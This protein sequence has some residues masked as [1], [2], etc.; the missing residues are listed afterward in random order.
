MAISENGVFSILPERFFSPLSGP[1][2]KHYA[3]L[4]LRFYR[5]FKENTR[6]ALREQVIGDFVE[7]VRAAGSIDQTEGDDNDEPDDTGELGTDERGTAAA[8]LRRLVDAGWLS[9]E[10]LSDYSR[11]VNITP[12]SRPFLE[13]LDK[14]EQGRTAEYE[15]HVVAV[16]SNLTGDAINDAGHLAVLSANRETQDLI[17]S[18][19]AL[20]QSIKDYYERLSDEESAKEVKDILHLQ[21]D[22][23]TID[24]LDA[25]YKRLKTSDNLSRYR[26]KIFAKI[27]ELLS[28]QQWLSENGRKLARIRQLSPDEGRKRITEMLEDIRDTLRALDPLQDE[29]DKRN[30]LYARSSIQRVKMLLEPDTTLAGKLSALAKALVNRDLPPIQTASALIPI[31]LYRIRTF[32]SNSLYRRY[33]RSE[34]KPAAAASLKDSAALEKDENK[35]LERLRRFL[36]VSKINDWLDEHGGKD[37]ILSASELVVD[38]QSFIRFVYSLLYA[39]SRKTFDYTLETPSSDAF[40]TDNVSGE[41]HT[42]GYVLPDVQLRHK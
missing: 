5:L 18:L 21:Y 12:W 20:S 19:K 41:V 34:V 28:N 38:E 9:E 35:F 26:P 31:N 8:F 23:Y 42:A 16:Y 2:R 7:Y 14:V 40:S 11:V 1:N 6:G 24:V 25:A 3:A 15:S 36:G 30:S 4:L 10:T 29:I 37:K 33:R 17:D 13:A 22:L 27:A 39:D 32:S